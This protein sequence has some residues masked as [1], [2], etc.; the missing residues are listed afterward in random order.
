M[1]E[2]D[3]EAAKAFEGTGDADGRVDV[4]QDVVFGP[5]VYLEASRLVQGG[6]HEGEEFLFFGSGIRKG[7]DGGV[8]RRS[9]YTF[10]TN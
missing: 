9:G 2:L 5:D 1:E 8:A 3:H 7:G 6:V 4:D 10:V